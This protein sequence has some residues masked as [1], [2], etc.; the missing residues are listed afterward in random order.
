MSPGDIVNFWYEVSVNNVRSVIAAD[1]LVIEVLEPFPAVLVLD[2]EWPP[3]D[4]EEQ[5][6]VW[7]NK[8]YGYTVRQGSVTSAKTKA[9]QSGT[10]TLIR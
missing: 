9:P 10:W 3:E 8:Y 7:V 4:I 6:G 1:A 5:A 2:V